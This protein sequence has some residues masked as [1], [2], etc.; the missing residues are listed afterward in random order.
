MTPLKKIRSEVKFHN[1][2]ISIKNFLKR[3][4]PRGLP[5][6]FEIYKDRC[7]I[8]IKSI[9]LKCKVLIFD[10]FFGLIF[11]LYWNWTFS[12]VNQKEF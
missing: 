9:K 1:N 6:F 4:K 2:D 7:R 5:K 10:T 8:F 12:K 11:T 3:W